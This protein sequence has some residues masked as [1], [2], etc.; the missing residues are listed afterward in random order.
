MLVPV[1]VVAFGAAY[2]ITELVD[3]GG[4]GGSAR[5]APAPAISFQQGRRI[6]I[7][8]GQRQL[9]ARLGPPLR[10]VRSHVHPPQVCRYYVITDQPGEQW[11]FC[12]ARGKLVS[13]IAGPV[14]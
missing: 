3:G 10:I 12:F 4:G 13:S 14:R 7:G 11:G 2:G 9:A 1:A 6:K 5:P 8:I